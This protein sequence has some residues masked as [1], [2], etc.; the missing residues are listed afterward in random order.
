MLYYIPTCMAMIRGV[1]GSRCWTMVYGINGT[2]SQ[3]RSSRH[4][5]H[6]QTHTCLV[7]ATP[8]KHR[9]VANNSH[10]SLPSIRHELCFTLFGN[11]HH[12]YIVD[13][14]TGGEATTTSA[15]FL[16]YPL[17]TTTTICFLILCRW[18]GL[19][20]LGLLRGRVWWRS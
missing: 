9:T 11:A 13:A 7:A 17:A 5:I 18:F 20:R 15:H 19:V 14:T 4:R 8:K 3:K 2:K 6:T 16:I 10:A 1:W 12:T